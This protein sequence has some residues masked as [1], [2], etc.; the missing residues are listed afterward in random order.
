M[1]GAIAFY[2]RKNQRDRTSLIISCKMILFF[3]KAGSFLLAMLT[4]TSG[5]L[6]FLKPTE[7]NK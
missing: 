6:K 4:K 2:L 5:I 1:K 3:L 7:E